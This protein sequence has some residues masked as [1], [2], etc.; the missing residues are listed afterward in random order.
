MI[1]GPLSRSLSTSAFDTLRLAMLVLLTEIAKREHQPALIDRITRLLQAIGRRPTYFSLLAETP[2]VAEQLIDIAASGDYLID[3][4]SRQPILLDELAVSVKRFGEFDHG[5]MHNDWLSALS[6][7][8]GDEEMQMDVL[9]Q[10]HG[11]QL[12]RVACAEIAQQISR[13]QANERLVWLAEITLTHARAIG[14]DAL[15]ERFPSIREGLDFGI[16]A[17]GKLGSG[18][19]SYHADLDVVFVYRQLDPQLNAEDCAVYANRLVRKV[20]SILSTRT[21]SGM[22]YEIDS[23]LRP[24]GRSGQLVVPLRAWQRYLEDNAWLWE[25]Q[26]LVRARMVLGSAASIEQFEAVRHQTLAQPRDRLALASEVLTMRKT[27]TEHNDTSDEHYFDLKL[28]DGGLVDVEFIVQF[29]VLAHGH[30]H[31]QLIQPR[32]CV[33]ILAAAAACKLIDET[34]A[35]TLAAAYNE[36]LDLSGEC[37]RSE[38]AARINIDQALTTRHTVRSAREQLLNIA[39]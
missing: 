23:R 17:Y 21:S 35:T 28:G 10:L 9:R 13:K 6:G 4:I 30:Y 37:K 32:S 29:L 19:L 14:A 16:I 22:I 34:L 39:V 5:Q 11:A 20:I 25:L 12:F 15:A 24:N 38:R 1:A 31:P 27:M 3:K 18:E 7:H 36:L 8:R 2:L 33:G 26:A